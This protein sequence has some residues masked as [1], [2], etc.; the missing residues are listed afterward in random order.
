MM[1]EFV[2][3]MIVEHQQ[4]TERINKLDVFLSNE[5][6]KL[7]IDVKEFAAMCVQINAMKNYR[8][9][10]E[11]RLHLHNIEVTDTGK[12]FEKLN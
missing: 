7:T 2:R 12:Y 9:S 8:A 11:I 6:N 5:A 4:L 3:R 10:L 1:K